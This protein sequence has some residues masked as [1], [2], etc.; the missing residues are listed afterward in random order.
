VVIV[1]GLVTD[2]SAEH[3]WNAYLPMLVTLLGIE[4]D[5]NDVHDANAYSPYNSND[6][7]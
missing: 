7:I 2:T 4:I 3:P 5:P 1:L 6:N